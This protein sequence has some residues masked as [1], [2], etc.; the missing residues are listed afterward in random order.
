M[1]AV[2]ANK[3]S[4]K[5]RIIEIF[6]AMKR[7]YKVEPTA[8]VTGSMLQE[9]SRKYPTPQLLQLAASLHQTPHRMNIVE[10][11]TLLHAY[12]HRGDIMNMEKTLTKMKQAGVKPN[13]ITYHVMM[14]AYG[15]IDVAKMEQIAQQMTQLG[16]LP[17]AITFQIRLNAHQ[18]LLIHHHHHHHQ[19]QQQQQQQQLSKFLAIFDELHTYSHTTGNLL[20]PPTSYEFVLQE[21]AASSEKSRMWHYYQLMKA[22][23]TPTK[24]A[25]ESMREVLKMEDRGGANADEVWELVNRMSKLGVEPP[26]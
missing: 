4:D 9:I 13:S 17:S 12:A 23:M 10:F 7:V 18:K 26:L 16:L 20:V 24:T 21:L 11:N 22:D 5:A 6:E 3:Q 14:Q 2:A 8:L 1:K 15:R 19:Q 25:L